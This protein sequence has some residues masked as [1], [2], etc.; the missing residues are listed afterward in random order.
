MSEQVKLR[1]RYREQK[2]NTKII[3]NGTVYDVDAEACVNVSSDD[4]QK[5]LANSRG[6]WVDAAEEPTE[7]SKPRPKRMAL[8]TADGSRIEKEEPEEAEA[9]GLEEPE[10]GPEEAEAVAPPAQEERPDAD[11]WPD[12]VEDMSADY[13]KAMAKAYGI[14]TQ[15][16]QRKSTLIRKIRAIREGTD[17]E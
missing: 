17:E 7:R 12:P 2:R 11:G 13:I 4:A 6:L 14:N 15:G 9:E 16:R 1:H 5:L 3:V 10:E 8:L